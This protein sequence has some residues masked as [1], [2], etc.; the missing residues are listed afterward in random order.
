MGWRRNKKERRATRALNTMK[1]KPYVLNFIESNFPKGSIILE[2]G[3]GKGTEDLINAGFGVFSIEHDPE[4]VDMYHDNYIE[5]PLVN[6]SKED[7]PLWWYDPECLKDKL[8]KIY[9]LLLIDGPTGKGDDYENCRLG[10][11]E[12]LDLFNRNVCI[13]VDDTDRP[14]EKKL[15]EILSEGRQFKDHGSFGMIWGDTDKKIQEEL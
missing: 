2:L 13:L 15:F 9:H 3:S 5:A 14:Q 1:L 8:P 7:N 4:W 6:L 10:I 11:L 12:N